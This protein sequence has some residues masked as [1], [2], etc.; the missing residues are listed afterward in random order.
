M[1]KINKKT[2]SY[3]YFGIIAIILFGAFVAIYQSDYIQQ[4]IGQRTADDGNLAPTATPTPT[5]KPHSNSGSGS[6]PTPAVTATPA[7]TP[8]I[9][10]SWLKIDVEPS[11][12]YAGESIYVTVEADCG[13]FYTTLNVH[14]HGG[15][16][17]WVDETVQ[18]WIDS[19][20]NT[21][22][23]EYSFTPDG[24]YHFEVSAD[25]EHAEDT[26]YVYPMQGLG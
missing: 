20:T 9:A 3:L 11:A 8:E 7:P 4:S 24:E 22:T 26:C 1:T 25:D 2:K 17:N 16:N 19:S 14:G 5:H 15:L 18:L 12:V 21:G 13:G 6:D 23:K 10:P